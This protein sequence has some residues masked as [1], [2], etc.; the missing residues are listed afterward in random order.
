[1]CIPVSSK[2]CFCQGK[3]QSGAPDDHKQNLTT[4]QKLCGP[5][6]TIANATQLANSPFKMS[7]IYGESGFKAISHNFSAV[8]ILNLASCPE[9][10]PLQSELQIKRQVGGI[11]T[12]W[13]LLHGSFSAEGPLLHTKLLGNC[14]DLSSRCQSPSTRE[15]TKQRK[16][17]KRK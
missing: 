12:A 17:C 15:I 4:P 5:R 16:S 10:K 14:L 11:G 1:M 6:S 8:P 13:A 7:G 3:Y 9:P 2:G